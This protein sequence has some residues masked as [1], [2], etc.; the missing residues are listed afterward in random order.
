MEQKQLDESEEDSF[1]GE[2]FIDDESSIINQKEKSS[3]LAE[4]TKE[5]KK[6]ASKKT[7][8][9]KKSVSKE[10]EGSIDTKSTPDK[11]TDEIKITPVNE[12]ME[13]EPV[14][15]PWA[16]D[17]EDE[18]GLFK[19]AS[20]WKVI[21]GIVV[22][23]LLISVF[24]QGFD[25]SR[26]SVTGASVLTLSEAEQ[27]ALD[28]VNNNLLQPPFLAEL[29]SSEDTGELYKVTLAVAGRNVDS[30]I[31]KDGRLFFPQGFDTTVDLES[32]IET[33][34]V[35]EEELGGEAEVVL[36]EVSVPEE[37]LIIDEEAAP[38]EEVVEEPVVEEAEE[39][40]VEEESAVEEVPVEE[41]PAATGQVKQLSVKSWKWT[42]EPKELR[43]K[44]GT[45]VKLTLVPTIPDTTK[46]YLNLA[47]YTFAIPDF[48]VEKEVAGSTTVEFTADKVG[49]FKFSCSSCEA[50]RGMTGTLIVE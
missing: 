5:E 38:E 46:P 6:S 50:K 32:Q 36:D 44:K 42:F 23:L 18:G 21:T 1:F 29:G 2:E 37:V 34:E 19:E 22:I 30:Y 41:E 43:V 33:P 15:D 28:Y 48:R 14:V 35:T 12:P 9:E 20:T 17:D 49:Q 24:T 39:V 47:S 7:K 27:K 31:T 8:T 26:E 45:L 13:N 4:K 3:S 25:F 10:E 40:P 16:D 11:I